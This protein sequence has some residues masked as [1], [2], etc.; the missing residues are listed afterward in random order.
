MLYTSDSE[1]FIVPGHLR[2]LWRNEAVQ[3]M[4]SSATSY[5][6]GGQL[7]IKVFPVAMT[8]KCFT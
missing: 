5:F 6:G 4:G 3:A 8:Q 1:A 2:F 7:H